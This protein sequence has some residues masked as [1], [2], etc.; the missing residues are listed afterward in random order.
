MPWMNLF[1]TSGL[2]SSGSHRSFDA[3]LLE[4][5]CEFDNLEV[6]LFITSTVLLCTMSRRTG[7]PA[8]SGG[9][10]GGKKPLDLSVVGGALTIDSDDEIIDTTPK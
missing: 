1:I 9:G 5:I 3:M 8:R 2:D 4:Y 7:R 6:F 10:G